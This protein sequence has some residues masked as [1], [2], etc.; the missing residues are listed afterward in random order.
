FFTILVV[1]SFSLRYCPVP[2]RLTVNTRSRSAT[3]SRM[4]HGVR[5]VSPTNVLIG[6]LTSVLVVYRTRLLT[7]PPVAQT[8]N[9]SGSHC[10]LLSA[11]SK[12]VRYELVIT[13]SKSVSL[14]GKGITSN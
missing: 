14:A 1:N 9:R 4:K 13:A 6:N 11:L 3:S 8:A 12:H 7:T 2:K 10:T 5:D